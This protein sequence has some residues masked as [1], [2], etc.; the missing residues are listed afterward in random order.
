MQETLFAALPLPDGWSPI[1][2][3]PSLFRRCHFA[4]YSDTRAFLG[5]LAALSWETGVYPNLAFGKT[6]VNVTLYAAD[7]GMP[8]AGEVDFASRASGLIDAA[9]A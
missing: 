3:P 2:H 6:H 1:Q 7:G 9:A 4:S 5:R 8:G